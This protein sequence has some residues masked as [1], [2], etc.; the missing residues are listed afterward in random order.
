MDALAE[1]DGL[2]Q[3]Y[4]L[5]RGFTEVCAPPP[6]LALPLQ[7]PL[8]PSHV[9]PCTVQAFTALRS[10]TQADPLRG[11]NVDSIVRHLDGRIRAFDMPGLL[12]TWLVLHERLFVRLDDASRALVS[13]LLLGL[14]RLY[15]IHAMRSRRPD[16]VRQFFAEF[17]SPPSKSK[18]KHGHAAAPASRQSLHRSATAPTRPSST[19]TSSPTAAGASVD[20][21]GSSGGGV[22]AS[23]TPPSAGGF[24]G[25]A[26]GDGSGLRAARRDAWRRLTRAAAEDADHSWRPWFSLPYCDDPRADPVFAPHFAP[27]WPAALMVTVRNVLSSVFHATPLPKLLAVNI[28]QRQ[29][30]ACVA[31]G[32]G[33]LTGL[34]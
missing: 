4:L 28:A 21:T 24:I 29:Q 14:Q 22:R 27:E 11:F 18:S 12:D 31:A 7:L 2:V 8:I 19:A 9:I 20:G 6:C 26:G 15:V 10:S 5:F 33:C 23:A 34:H 17:V 16:L 25:G 30:Q 32:S 1:V 3:E 13:R